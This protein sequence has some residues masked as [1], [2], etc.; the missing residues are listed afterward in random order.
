MTLAN[1][2]TLA[3]E[4]TKSSDKV[5]THSFEQFLNKWICPFKLEKTPCRGCIPFFFFFANSLFFFFSPFYLEKNQRS[6]NPLPTMSSHSSEKTEISDYKLIYEQIENRITSGKLSSFLSFF[7]P[8][9]LLSH[10]QI[11]R[12]LPPLHSLCF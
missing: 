8:T 1:T 9:T 3:K 11:K 7:S 6:A 10:H 2:R 5:I 4:K 12:E